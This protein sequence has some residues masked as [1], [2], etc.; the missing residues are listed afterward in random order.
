MSN[1]NEPRILVVD[2]DADICHNLLDILVIED[3]DDARENLRDILELD[4]YRVVTAGTAAEAF[5]R[6]D[7]PRFSAI[8]LDRRLPDAMAEQIL[9]RLRS[10]APDAAVIVVTGYADLQGAITALRF[11]ATDYI[12]KP[13]NAD[14]LRASLARIAE[15]R[16]LAR[17]T[18]RSEAVFRHLVEAAEC[19]VV[20]VRRDHT[21][22]YFSPFA[23]RLTGRTLDEVRG[24]DYLSLLLPESDRQ[25]MARELERVVE[26]RP[27][28]GFESRII[29]RE[30]SR[31]W[32][33]WNARYL[34][35]YEDAPAVLMVGNDIT[36][37]KEAQD[38]ALQSERLAAIGQ[39]V[40]GL[41]HE[42]RNAL[43]R[44]QACLEMLALTV[45]DR[46]NALALIE[47]LQTA[48]NH[49]HYLYEDVRGYA[50]P[51]KLEKSVHNL[52]AI[53]R[54]AW[55]HLETARK[56]KE[57]SLHEQ[58]EEI[59]LRCKVDPFRLE[60]VFRNI[61][62][63]ALAACSPPIIVEINAAAVMLGSR[64][65]LRIS[66]RD[67]GPGIRPEE[68]Q[69][70]FDPFYTTKAKGTGLGLPIARRIIEAHEGQIELGD[71]R[72]PGA[73]FLI[74]LPRGT[75]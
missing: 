73:V 31:R 13:L 61:F 74:T 18:E 23:E 30:S 70:V 39:M 32:L 37:L 28:H 29:C 71:A 52:A 24:C 10:A 6:D 49:L 64:A 15:R 5:A 1:G 38:R 62:D 4:L 59:D 11:G 21:I 58:V 9:P 72:S 33:I 50:S 26:G 66:V 14:L 56:G 60:Q 3:D 48:Q 51:I 16:R 46:P 44:S 12:L 67:N 40:T 63:N 20:I 42:S 36:F 25:A 68:R 2:D 7:W 43:A 22:V 69:K 65:G 75:P 45:Q 19:L 57:A 34:P 8:I 41:A 27:T 53:W 55:A 35:D 47:R 54:E 17:A